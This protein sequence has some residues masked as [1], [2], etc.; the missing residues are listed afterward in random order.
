M[1]NSVF[2]IYPVRSSM[3]VWSFTDDDVG[4]KN[5]PFVGMI[6]VYMDYMTKDIVNAEKGFPLYFSKIKLPNTKMTLHKV[7]GDEF[8][9][10]YKFEELDMAEGWLCPALFKYFD[11]APDTFYIG[12]D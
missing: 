3:G 11:V 7:S 1:N 12:C 10:Y 4:L 2:V 5:E 6:N 8:G 9:T